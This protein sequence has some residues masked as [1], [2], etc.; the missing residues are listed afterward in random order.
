[1]A[2]WKS[3]FSVKN[4]SL[5]HITKNLGEIFP[6]D[7]NENTNVFYKRL[8]SLEPYKLYQKAEIF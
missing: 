8:Q 4:I 1:M 7:F 5:S 3:L 2:I 6:P